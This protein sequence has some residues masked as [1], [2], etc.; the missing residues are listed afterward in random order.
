MMGISVNPE[1]LLVVR[2]DA[3]KRRLEDMASGD[4]VLV[5]GHLKCLRR[6]VGGVDLVTRDG[7]YY[8]AHSVQRF[9]KQDDVELIEWSDQDDG[10]DRGE[11]DGYDDHLGSAD[12]TRST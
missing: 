9:L 6:I 8:G 2:P 1:G 12:W 11:R 7:R 10:S 5:G 3:P 4:Y